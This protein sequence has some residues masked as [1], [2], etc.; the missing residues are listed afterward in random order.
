M[1]AM[2]LTNFRKLSIAPLPNTFDSFWTMIWEQ[3]TSVIVMLSKLIE[4]EQVKCDQYWPNNGTLI[5]SDKLIVTHLET[6]ELA[7]YV[8]RCFELKKD[9]ILFYGVK[10]FFDKKQT[11]QNGIADNKKLRK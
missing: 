7:N 6:N 4:M 1:E 2:K 3:N 5:F 10:C 8:I 9:N 11:N